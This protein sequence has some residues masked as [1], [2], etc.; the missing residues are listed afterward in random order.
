MSNFLELELL[1]HVLNGLTWASPASVWVALYTTD[2]TDADSGTE[3]AALYDYARVQMTAGWTVAAGNAYNTAAVTFPPANGGSWGTVTHMG[4]RD[5]STA[6]NLL[7]HG[8][9]T[10]SRTVQ[11]GDTF[12]FALGNISIDLD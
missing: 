7:F 10:S 2:P 6:G 11:D 1:D 12:Q 3:V 5:A 4:I 9:L 8:V